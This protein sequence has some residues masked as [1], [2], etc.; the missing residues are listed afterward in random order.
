MLEILGGAAPPEAIFDRVDD[1]DGL[2]FLEFLLEYARLLRGDERALVH[3]MAE[4]YL[5]LVVPELRRGTAESR[6]HAVLILARMGMPRYAHV[7]TDALRDD[8][9]IVAMIAA[10]SLFRPG[11][12]RHF[13]AVLEHLPRFTSWSR[14]FLASMLAGGGPEAAPLLRAILMDPM[15]DALVRAVAS[16]ALRE[17]ND[18]RSVPLALELLEQAPSPRPSGHAPSPPPLDKELLV[19][20]L[21]ILEHLGHREHLPTVRKHVDSPDPVI[22][23]A[24]V[25]ALAGLGGEPEIP[26]LQSR[27]DDDTFWVSLEAA[28]GLMSLGETATLERIAISDGPWSLLAQQVLTE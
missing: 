1:G 18:L 10:R 25:S 8:S 6:G 20:C 28:R 13:P 22:R 21:R 17:L 27:L 19:G 5:P 26:V 16:D 12:E 15:E 23:A 14:S 9:P 4:P 2:D 24:A 11:H 7:V 3:A